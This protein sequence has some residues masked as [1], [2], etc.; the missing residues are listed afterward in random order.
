MA[1]SKYQ[2]LAIVE[3]TKGNINNIV[4]HLLDGGNVYLDKSLMLFS[5]GECG[6]V[7]VC[8][9]PSY[10]SVG[11]IHTVCHIH[12]RKDP[13][14]SKRIPLPKE[15]ELREKMYDLLFL[16]LSDTEIIHSMW[17][18]AKKARMCVHVWPSV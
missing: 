11:T 8:E 1:R 16:V 2:E 5:L 12:T 3:P 18:E 6:C 14:G 13:S 9:T 4:A 10:R 7:S 15:G 17:R